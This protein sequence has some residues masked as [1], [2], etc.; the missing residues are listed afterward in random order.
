M[1]TI[2]GRHDNGGALGVKFLG[3]LAH[4][5]H[6]AAWIGSF[7]LDIEM[8]LQQ[9]SQLPAIDL[10]RLQRDCDWVKQRMPSLQA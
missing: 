5:I 1:C 2:P 9:V 4:G 8:D 10:K 6:L 7:V 3:M